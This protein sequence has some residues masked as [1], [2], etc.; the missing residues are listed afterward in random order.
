MSPMAYAHG[1]VWVT[2]YRGDLVAA[3]DQTQ[4]NGMLSELQPGT[5]AHLRMAG[6]KASP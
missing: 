5:R 3:I 6:E 4:S 2:S 1:L